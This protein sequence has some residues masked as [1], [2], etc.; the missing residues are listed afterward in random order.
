MMQMYNIASGG[1]GAT[2]QDFTDYTVE[3]LLTR[4]PFAMLGY[5]WYGCTNG[6]EAPLRAKEWDEDYGTPDKDG[7][8]CA[9]TG[10]D[11]GIF[12]RTY[13]VPQGRG[14]VS[15]ATVTWDC[16]KGHGEINQV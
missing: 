7:A 16:A 15:V 3:F 2:E 9:E 13:T 14:G 4:G 6:D 5:S 1:K 12:T 10:A 8:V 11:T